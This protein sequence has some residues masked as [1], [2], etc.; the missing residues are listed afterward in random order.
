MALRLR[1]LV[2]PSGMRGAM[3]SAAP[4]RGAERA[5]SG[6]LN[7]K[8]PLRDPLRSPS[9]EGQFSQISGKKRRPFFI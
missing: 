2:W 6:D 4:R 1:A 3:K 8:T 7:R 9:N 5:R